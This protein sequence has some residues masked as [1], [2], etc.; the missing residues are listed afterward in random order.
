MKNDML[1]L[2]NQTYLDDR[3]I[4]KQQHGFVL[5]IPKTD[6][7]TISTDYGPIALV[8]TDYKIAARIIAKRIR[9]ALSD[10]IRP[11]QYCGVPGNTIWDAVMAVRDAYPE[12][13]HAPLCRLSLDFTAVLYMISHTSLLLM[14]KIMTMV[15]NSSQSYKR[16][17]AWPSAR[18]KLMATLQDTFSYNVSLNKAVQW[19]SFYSLWFWMSCYV[20]WSHIVGAS[21]LD[22]SKENRGAGIHWQFNDFCDVICRF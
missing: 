3:A 15:W 13:T 4:A 9:S 20:C 6:S 21:Q 19:T 18:D 7:P 22:T 2:C 16:Y 1:A 12:L 11:S 17:M 10:M 14:L 5:C 8:I